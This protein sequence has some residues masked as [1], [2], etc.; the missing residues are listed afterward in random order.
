MDIN[1]IK[2]VNTYIYLQWFDWTLL[3][4]STEHNIEAPT[5]AAAAWPPPWRESVKE[6]KIFHQINLDT[7]AQDY[8]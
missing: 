8:G 3:S 7:D 1:V 6:W 2:P 5:T 4:V